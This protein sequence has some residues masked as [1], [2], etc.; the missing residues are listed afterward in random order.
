MGAS[1]FTVHRLDETDSTNDW[2]LAASRDGAPDRTVVIAGYQRRG[3]GRLDRRWEAP[4]G[5]ALLCSV[6]LRAVLGVEDRHL[7]AVAVALAAA[8]GCDATSG[9]DVGLKWPNDLVVRDRKLGGVLAETDGR[10]DDAGAVA[11]VVGLGVNLTWPGPPA[12]SGTSILEATGTK[13]E[14]DALLGA[15]LEALDARDAQ[16]RSAAGRGA[17]VAAYRARLVTLGRQVAVQLHDETFEGTAVDVTDH[18]HLVVATDEGAR[19]IAAGDV[20]HLRPAA[21]GRAEAPE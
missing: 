13:V 20:V 5:S 14:P 18:G 19:V 9:L 16:L 12:A 10:A 8:Q 2:A 3:R 4:P 7:C 6:L 21:E 11:V 15:S 1:G 17:L